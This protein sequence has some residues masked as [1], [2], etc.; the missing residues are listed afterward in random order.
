MSGAADPRLTFTYWRRA[1]GGSNL[2]LTLDEVERAAI[3]AVEETRAGRKTCAWHEAARV[4]QTRCQCT[5]C[6][7]RLVPPP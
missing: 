6:G 4:K 1:I 2:G 5:D 3:R 7:G